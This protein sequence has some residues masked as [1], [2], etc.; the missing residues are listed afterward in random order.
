MHFDLLLSPSCRGPLLTCPRSLITCPQLKKEK[1]GGGTSYIFK[2]PW[3]QIS[4]LLLLPLV[5]ASPSGALSS[6]FR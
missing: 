3:F 1:V 5:L 2:F 4:P 6:S